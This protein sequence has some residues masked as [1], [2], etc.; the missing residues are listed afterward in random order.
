MGGASLGS[1]R[2]PY[3]PRHQVR[4]GF[5]IMLAVSLVNV[6]LNLLFEPSAWWALLPIAIFAFGW[7]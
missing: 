4:H 5:V 6:A 3:Q 1:A 2:R 7:A